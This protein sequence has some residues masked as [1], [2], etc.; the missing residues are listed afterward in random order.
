MYVYELY[1]CILHVGTSPVH[2]HSTLVLEKKNITHC[3]ARDQL[4]T[5]CS[6]VKDLHIGGNALSS[7]ESVSQLEGRVVREQ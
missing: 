5:L 1:L 4:S 7:W 3:G 6:C 2:T